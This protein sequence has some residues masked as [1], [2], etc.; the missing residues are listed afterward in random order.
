MIYDPGRFC[1]PGVIERDKESRISWL[2]CHVVASEHGRQLMVGRS[3][4]EIF[5]ICGYAEVARAH[6][7]NDGLQIVFLSPGDANL[8]ILQLALH[9][10]TLRLDRLNNFL[11]FVSLQALSNFQFLSRMADG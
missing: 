8:S 9:L 1:Q 6:E 4:A 11:G 7:L 2:A 10:E 5:E 3:V